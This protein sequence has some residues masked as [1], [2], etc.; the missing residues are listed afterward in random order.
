[1]HNTKNGGHFGVLQTFKKLA[2]QF[3]WPKIYQVVQEYVK[4]CDTCQWVKS[5]T[6]SPAGLLQPLPVPYQVG[7]TSL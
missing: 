4:K 7:T 1:M 2:Q 5:E 3:Y 6:L